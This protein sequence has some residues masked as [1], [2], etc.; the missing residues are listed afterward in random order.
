MSQFY[1]I[2]KLFT[3]LFLPPGLFV[4]LFVLAALFAKKFRAFFLASAFVFYALAN[5]FVS[6]MLLAPLEKPFRNFEPQRVDALVILAGG[7]VADS[8]NIPLSP[9]AYK[10]A[11]WGIMQ[12]RSQDLPILFSGAGI[13]KYTEAAAFLASTHELEQYLHV[14][15]PNSLD[16]SDK[17]FSMLVEDKSLDTYENARYS[18]EIF[19]HF[20][21]KK[22]KI[23]LVTSAYHMRRSIKLYEHFGFEVVANATDFLISNAERT[24]W[25]YLP[26]M[27]AFKNSY[28]AL[29]EYFGL[30]SLY[31][32]GVY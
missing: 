18:Y 31:L 28:R 19:Q 30:L 22:P 16:L 25:D 14:S 10:R 3:Y 26:S 15:I 1:I 27:D 4:F 9:S 17:R 20:G 23:Y 13:T 29:H 8:P 12:A 6:D 21:I 7:S 32:K 24:N 2:S 5:S 11:I